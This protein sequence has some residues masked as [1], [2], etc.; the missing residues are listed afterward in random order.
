[1]SEVVSVAVEQYIER[2]TAERERREA[3]RVEK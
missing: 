3:L 1:M 2:E